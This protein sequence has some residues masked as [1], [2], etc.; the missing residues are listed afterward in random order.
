MLTA[1]ACAR[2]QDPVHLLPHNYR[3]V[4]ENENVKVIHVLYRPHEKLPLPDHS[5]KPTVYVYVTNS[6]PVR[7]SHVEDHPFSL[8]RPTEM[9]GTF[10]VSPCRIEKHAVENLEDIPTEFLRIEL[11][12]VPLGFQRN[13]FR[14]PKVVRSNA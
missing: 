2:A 5:D 3:L 14:S 9:A 11:E 13:S 6:G 4:Y 7:F 10:R 8:L 1:A 12:R